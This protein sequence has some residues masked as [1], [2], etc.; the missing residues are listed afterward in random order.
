[1]PSPPSLRSKRSSA[2]DVFAIR[3]YFRTS[4]CRPPAA[5][6]TTMLSL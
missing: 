6:A 4:P 5:T 3:P 1:M 2:A